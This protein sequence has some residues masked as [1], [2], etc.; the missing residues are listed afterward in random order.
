MS[1]ASRLV[2]FGSFSDSLHNLDTTL[3]LVSPGLL[4]ICWTKYSKTS[5]V[6]TRK[7]LNKT[8][9]LSTSTQNEGDEEEWMI[10]NVSS[11]GANFHTVSFTSMQLNCEVFE[12]FTV[13]NSFH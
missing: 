9:A 5:K 2:V 12:S 4:A 10:Q 8:M 6:S 1:P 7:K 11:F 3:V 13:D